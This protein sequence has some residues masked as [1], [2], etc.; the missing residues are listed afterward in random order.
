M[1]SFPFS[2][3]WASQ[4]RVAVLLFLGFWWTWWTVGLELHPSVIPEKPCKGIGIKPP[5]PKLCY[6]WSKDVM[7][8][9]WQ[10]AKK[11]QTLI[12]PEGYTR[13]PCF[14][15]NYCLSLK[16]KSFLKPQII[17]L[18]RIMFSITPIKTWRKLWISA[19]HEYIR[20]MFPSMP[21][22]FIL[23]SFCVDFS[24][25]TLSPASRLSASGSLGDG[26]YSGDSDTSTY[27]P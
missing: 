16:P 12:T 9:Q 22:P 11:T 27:T 15:R 26:Q 18:C 23:Q 1:F 17:R 10:H 3:A 4:Q 21:L 7:V 25:G 19:H 24:Q 6:L 2:L 5:A 14:L 8:K 13:F 20:Y